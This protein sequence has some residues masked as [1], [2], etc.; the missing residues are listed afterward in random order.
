M[1]KRLVER[2]NVVVE[3]TLRS[4]TTRT[5]Q[6]V[7]WSEDGRLALA[8]NHGVCIVSLGASRESWYDRT[9]ET[10][11]RRIELRHH[12]I[13]SDEA[14][15]SIAWG[16]QAW[17]KRCLLAATRASGLCAVYEPPKD[18]S[19]FEWVQ[20][21]VVTSRA[22]AVT[23]GPDLAVATPD[24]VIVWRPG[25][26]VREVAARQPTAVA[27]LGNDLFI[28][29]AKGSVYCETQRL[30]EP[31]GRCVCVISPGTDVVV[32]AAVAR[33]HTLGPR[34]A[35][36][37][38]GRTVVSAR[39]LVRSSV[40]VTC[41]SDGDVEAWQLPG[42][43]RL[44]SSRAA[45]TFGFDVSPL[46]LFCA[47]LDTIPPDAAKRN[48]PGACLRVAALFG[49][50]EDEPLVPRGHG[51]EWLWTFFVL[52]R[53]RVEKRVSAIIE[54]RPE[55]DDS[56]LSWLHKCQ[57][58]YLKHLL[59]ALANDKSA[60]ANL[61]HKPEVSGPC[62]LCG[63]PLR[64]AD[65]D[66]RATCAAGH[67]VLLCSRTKRPIPLDSPCV[68]SYVAPHFFTADGFAP[69]VASLPLLLATALSARPSCV[70]RNLTPFCRHCRVFCSRPSS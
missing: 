22:S 11:S 38:L 15:S 3:L 6:C 48:D 28:G 24:K 25:G 46:G 4:S 40:L 45:L 1:E 55:P 54:G 69:P 65:L 2:S 64:S 41:T 19:S 7:A 43:S 42:L 34:G 53:Q 8:L 39:R 23:W 44:S 12:W 56:S 30:R 13:R 33:L 59:A 17:D 67:V 50:L 5:V 52:A 51:Q 18:A 21:H 10:L 57:D 47:F 32:V 36:A 49:D 35:T 27:F 37:D 70:V 29:T 26:V 66:Y 9:P 58:P 61:R 60:I 63:E 31:D 16:G 20:A 68:L 62:P 14:T